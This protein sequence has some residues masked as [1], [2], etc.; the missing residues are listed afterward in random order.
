MNA[1]PVIHA[2]GRGETPP[3]PEPERATVAVPARPTARCYCPI[4]ECGYVGR[5][6]GPDRELAAAT[7]RAAE[8]RHWS[9]VHAAA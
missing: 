7:A 8:R 2:A 6:F 5:G 1:V 3:A 4:M 9:R